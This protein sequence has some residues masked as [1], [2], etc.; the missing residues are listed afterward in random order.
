MKKFSLFL[1]CVMMALCAILFVPKTQAAVSAEVLTSS[2]LYSI[3]NG[4]DYDL[5]QD[6]DCEVDTEK[7]TPVEQYNN[8]IDGHGFAI[9]NLTIYAYAETGKVGFLGATNGAVIKNLKF[10]NLNIVVSH[11][12]DLHVSKVGLLVG[13]ATNTKIENCS[14]E[15]CTITV[16]SISSLYA[17]G[18]A[19]EIKDG[20]QVKNVAV[21]CDIVAN[22]TGLSST[23]QFYVGEL[24]GKISNVSAINTVTSGEI[25]VAT[26][27]QDACVGGYAGYV[28]G[29][30]TKIKNN[31][32][33]GE[34]TK[35]LKTEEAEFAFVGK[36]VGSFVGRLSCESDIP[37]MGS[38]N[39]FYST[40][41]NPLFGNESE[42]NDYNSKVSQAGSSSILTPF[43]LD[44]LTV[45][46]GVNP[47]DV[48]RQDFYLNEEKWD[49]TYPWDFT[50]VWSIQDKVSLPQI[51]NFLTF[52]YT[53]NHDK[54]FETFEKPVLESGN[55]IILF[56]SKL[57]DSYKYGG[58]VTLEASITSENNL[59]KFFDI[60]G[61][62]HN[63]ETIFVNSEAEVVEETEN[64][65]QLKQDDITLTITTVGDKNQYSYKIDNC[66]VTDSG[67]YSVVLETIKYEL[68]VKSE[69]IDKGTV[70]RKSADASV[71][72]EQII[73]T[74]SY[75]QRLGYVTTPTEDFAFDCWTFDPEKE[76]AKLKSED[77]DVE[78]VFDER[79]FMEGGL[80]AN[81]EL[82]QDELVLYSTFTRA[83]CQI[84]FRFAVNN[85]I[86]T[87]NISSILIND[88]VVT[89]T[90]EGVITYKAKMGETYTLSVQLPPEYKFVGWF[91]SDGTSNVRDLSSLITMEMTA[92]KDS[93][94][95]IVVAN[96]AKEVENSENDSALLWIIIGC[97]GGLT[98]C[99]VVIIL[100]VK[101]KKDNS[102][103]SMY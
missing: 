36:Y 32:Y 76:E 96:F 87:E 46:K 57:S 5:S 79:A 90:E 12:V 47:I 20:S 53:V 40:D 94:T 97:A 21:D 35:G 26:Q 28:A 102:Y 19:G 9:K 60:I 33:S 22:Q 61:L 10:E 92:S 3:Q 91:E 68:T 99:V 45:Q 62:K 37:D 81:F 93:D 43:P 101:K 98:L 71:K 42:I 52:E 6:I 56:E 2:N 48:L 86:I 8:T 17:G 65:K 84:T 78:F 4:V 59:D 11:D 66:N 83:I 13:E 74:V 39:Y 7:F 95:M 64:T 18:L 14:F 25:T 69:N 24:A 15:N 50:N 41:E 73:D 1:G 38:L 31:V 63:S 54:S 29:D 44:I 85:K 88:K 89:P 70:R 27:N 67:E 55:S 77:E 103:K 80:F 82:G 30:Y 51:Q 16:D 34:I 58:S 23:K 75:G 72:E 49:F 100:I